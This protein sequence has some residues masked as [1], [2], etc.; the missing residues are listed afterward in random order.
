MILEATR[1]PSWGHSSVVLGA[2]VSF[3]EPFCGNLS[4]N[5]D[6]VC[7]ELTLR[8]PQERM[9]REVPQIITEHFVLP[10]EI[11]KCKENVR[12]GTTC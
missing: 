2:I 3:L 8:Y 11:N 5:I 7:E 6:K 1:D 9:M 10:L 12:P 4:P